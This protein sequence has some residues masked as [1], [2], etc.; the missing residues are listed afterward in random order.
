MN[1]V[2]RIIC[3]AAIIGLTLLA[4]CADGPATTSVAPAP[5]PAQ[6]IVSLAPG[7]TEILFALGL[8]DKIVGVTDYCNYPPEA[9][10]KPG[11]GGFSTPNIE[12]VVAKDPDLVLAANIHIDKVVPQL[13][14]RG[15]NVVVLN[16][17][18]I[19]EVLE[20]ITRVGQLT[21]R[22]KEA[23]ALTEDMR[24]RVDAVVFKVAPLSY[25]TPACFVVWHE[26]LMLAGQGTL[27]DELIGKAGG[28]NIA[29]LSDLNLKEG[30][31][32]IS[33]EA[34]ITAD[35]EVIFVGV[36]MGTGQ[37]KPLRFIQA[38]PRLE[39]I[40]ARINDRVYA[41]DQ[42]IAGRAGPRIVDA[43]ERFAADIHPELFK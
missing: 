41:V 35:P 14:A 25:L 2:L 10:E 22:E 23:Q 43:L 28:I 19:D 6:R 9:R 11:I 32:G 33:L 37:D 30:Y 26:P 24:R 34:F 21:G 8:A 42:D 7:N 36:G 31:P 12:E 1:Q 38:E 3:L 13:E 18:S 20:A 39:D 16:P 4:A 29:G 17:K 5:A 15:L 40:A 27:Q